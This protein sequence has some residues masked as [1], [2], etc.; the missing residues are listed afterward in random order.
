MWFK[1]GMFL[2]CM[3]ISAGISL[4]VSQLIVGIKMS[5]VPYWPSRINYQF[6]ALGFI[7]FLIGLLVFAFTNATEP[8]Q[9][10]S[11]CP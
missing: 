4:G 3:L 11:T 9:R 5:N 2:S 10:D 7:V 6:A 1:I 8:Q